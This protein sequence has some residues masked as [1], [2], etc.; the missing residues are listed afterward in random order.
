[1]ENITAIHDDLYDYL[2]KR[3]EKDTNFRFTLRSTNNVR[4]EKGYWFQGNEHY[5]TVSFWKSS[6]YNQTTT[7][8]AF[9]VTNDGSSSLEL[10]AHKKY[11]ELII[12]KEDIGSIDTVEVERENYVEDFFSK[13]ADALYMQQKKSSNDEFRW[14]KDYKGTDYIASLETFLKRDKTT[15]DAFIQ[16]EKMQKIFSVIPKEAF[17]ATISEINKIKLTIE[18]KKLR[19]E[20][21]ESYD[22]KPVKI[23]DLTIKNISLFKSEQ[24]IEFHKNLTCFIGLN[25]TGKTSLLKA[26]VLA[27]TGYEQNEKQGTDKIVELNDKLQN[28]LHIVGEKNG[29]AIYANDG[30]AEVSYTIQMNGNAPDE[31]KNTV[32]LRKQEDI[33]V[34][35]DESNSDFRSI[36][37]D[38]Y[39]CLFIAIPQLQ[40]EMKENAKKDKR[41]LYPN[42]NDAISM[43]S[44]HPE[45]R[46]SVFADWLRGL[47][48][49]AN[50]KQAKGETNPTERVLLNDVFKTISKITGEEVSLHK[51]FV[52]VD[53]D[54]P[55]PI[56]VNIGNANEPILLDLVS[57]GY[58][59]VFSFIGN[60]LQRLV[61]VTPKGNDYTQ[62][63]AIVLIDEI[64]TYLHPQWQ[65]TILDYLVESLPHVQF[66]VTTHSPYMVGSIPND[67]IKIYVCEKEGFDTKVEALDNSKGL[68][69]AN[70][71]RLTRTV[72]RTSARG[73]PNFEKTITELREAIQMSEFNK[74]GSMLNELNKAN[75]VENDPELISI[76]LSLKTKKRLAG[77]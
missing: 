29:R 35:S 70:I 39:K 71:D 22:Y 77:V 4:F 9:I 69:G 31:Y 41:P 1:M 50:D 72:F 20:N 7:N 45:D 2:S 28:L 33:V 34:I 26:L 38:K 62:T 40:G 13:V 18:L 14:V 56:W 37:D 64:D 57:Q 5:L 3:Y 63:P 32:L 53:T 17:E 51:I 61:E 76:K 6:L 43:L 36:I 58:N 75:L 60:I 47:N 27:F 55:D 10:V 66:I 15:I 67:K 49:V 16:S 8:I 54:I 46:F 68:Y 48:N 24:T 59:T 23:S 21:T 11:R 65:Y 19:I 44:G 74:A 52:T 12:E 25:G 42:I 30:F 73:I